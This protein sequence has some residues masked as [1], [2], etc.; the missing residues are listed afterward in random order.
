MGGFHNRSNTLVHLLHCLLGAI[1]VSFIGLHCE[2]VEA[3]SSFSFDKRFR[4]CC[5]CLRLVLKL[6]AFGRLPIS[7]Y[8]RQ[9]NGSGEST[10]L[11]RSRSI[12]VELPSCEM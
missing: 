6:I 3:V 12:A 7:M 2:S 5:P 9:P 11:L 1:E 4:C 8:C 10:V